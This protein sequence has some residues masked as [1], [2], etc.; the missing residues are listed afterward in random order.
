MNRPTD[1]EIL[2]FVPKSATTFFGAE[3]RRCLTTSELIEFAD[4]LLAGAEQSSR[5]DADMLTI[6]YM[7]GFEKGKAAGMKSSER[8]AQK[9]IGRSEM[10]EYFDAQKAAVEIPRSALT[11]FID[12]YCLGKP[13]IVSVAEAAFFAFNKSISGVDKQKVRDDA[14][15]EAAWTVENYWSAW[16]ML[17]PEKSQAIAS[18][19][20]R[21]IRALKS[22]PAAPVPTN[23]EAVLRDALQAI[24]NSVPFGHSHMR[25]QQD[26]IKAL[27]TASIEEEPAVPKNGICPDGKPCST[28]C[29]KGC[30][31]MPTGDYDPHASALVAQQEPVAWLN[32]KY[33]TLHFAGNLTDC[34][35]VTEIV[36]LYAAPQ[37]IPQDKMIEV[38]VVK[39]WQ[40]GEGQWTAGVT[41]DMFEKLPDKTK[42]YAAES[43]LQP[44]EQ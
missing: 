15:E 10:D 19:F 30:A 9:E 42:L 34:A 24:L 7:D 44:K 14:L 35:D 23:N 36:P 31:R 12:K 38:G 21:N 6:A 28:G 41:N 29:R 17:P 16:S 20:T 2:A 25:V 5:D 4:A 39:R 32:K 18:F 11:E 22:S 27:A 8:E 37:P 40:H 26:A 33:N 1:Q 13:E 3:V 43:D